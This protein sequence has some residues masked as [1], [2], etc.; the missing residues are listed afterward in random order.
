MDRMP[1]IVF[2]RKAGCRG[3]CLPGS[4][5]GSALD[6]ITVQGVSPGFCLSTG[7]GET[8][9]AKLCILWSLPS[10][11]VEPTACAS[12]LAALGCGSCAR[13]CA[14]A[15]TKDLDVALLCSH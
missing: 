1:L 12:G 15:T 10:R 3:S 14:G 9:L 4:E 7:L 8:E 6:L 5:I 2:Q 11:G 13:D